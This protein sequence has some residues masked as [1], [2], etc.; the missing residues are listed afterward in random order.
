MTTPNYVT[1]DQ[2]KAYTRSGSMNESVV[3]A[4]DPLMAQAIATASRA[5]DSYTGRRFYADGSATARTFNSAQIIRSVGPT[6]VGE[7]LDVYDISDPAS[8]IVKT[9]TDGD[10]VFETTWTTADYYTEP[11]N[12]VVD[13][14]EG[15]PVTRIIAVST[16]QLFPIPIQW[17]YL[18]P[19]IQVTAKW[20]WAAIPDVV[21]SA[22]LMTALDLLSMKDAKFGNIGWGEYGPV[23]ARANLKVA[24]LLDESYCR[25]TVGIA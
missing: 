20:G 14:L 2:F 25:T 7:R 12:G 10:G 19:S 24:E 5:I 11:L 8:I 22:T 23:R 16:R 6:F 17:A 9:D 3:S 18:K 13:G 21:V 15:W 4:A 1:V